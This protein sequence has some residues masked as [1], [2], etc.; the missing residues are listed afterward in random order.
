LYPSGVFILDRHCSVVGR[1]WDL[2]AMR[3]FHEGIESDPTQVGIQNQKQ[4]I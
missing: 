1:S 3:S 2:D 4:R